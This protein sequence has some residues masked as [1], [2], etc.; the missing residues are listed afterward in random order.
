[1]SYTEIYTFPEKG[2]GC[3]E[4][5]FQNSHGGA[6]YVWNRLAEEYCN[7][8]NGGFMQDYRPVWDLLN[9]EIEVFKRLVLVSTFD[10]VLFRGKELLILAD[11]MDEFIEYYKEQ[12]KDWA[13]NLPDQARVLRDLFNSDPRP[14]AVGWNQTS[15]NGDMWSYCPPGEDDSQTSDLSIDTDHWFAMGE[16]YACEC[17]KPRSS[18]DC[19]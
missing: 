14:F 1:M 6:L 4:A 7:A 18:C 11:A 10:Y 13:C 19:K 15:V 8:N 17:G 5:E 3:Q 9:K 16:G 12:S 2:E